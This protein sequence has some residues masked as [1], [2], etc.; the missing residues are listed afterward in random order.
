M[1]N[2]DKIEKADNIK[3]YLFRMA[4]HT[5]SDYYR[6][7]SNQ[8]NSELKEDIDFFEET[9][10]S[11]KSLQLADCCLG[12]MI[13]SLEPAYRE[14]L[15]LTELEGLTQR[16]YAEKIGIT[17]ANAKIRVHRAKLKLK[18]VIQSCCTYYFDKYGNVVDRDTKGCCS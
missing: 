17:V 18:E 4:D 3:S 16:Q 6:V 11:G 7:K 5:V 10:L 14:A 15:I 2:I 12:P 9:P 13:E 1:H 8:P